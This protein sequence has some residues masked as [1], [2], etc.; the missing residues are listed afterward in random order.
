MSKAQFDRIS[1]IYE[2]LTIDVESWSLMFEQSIL[3]IA[4]GNHYHVIRRFIKERKVVLV[5]E[6]TN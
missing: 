5:L 6:K 1:K 2:V 4:N 3:A